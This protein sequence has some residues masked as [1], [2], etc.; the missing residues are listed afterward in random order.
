M[1]PAHKGSRRVSQVVD[2]LAQELINLQDRRGDD[3]LL[4]VHRHLR[5]EQRRVLL[6]LQHALEKAHTAQNH[7]GDAVVDALLPVVIV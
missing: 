2:T 5:T 6:A 7:L 4:A 3:Q 1:L